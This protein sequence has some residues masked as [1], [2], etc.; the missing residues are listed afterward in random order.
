MVQ[1]GVDMGNTQVFGYDK[2]KAAA[3]SAAVLDIPGCVRGAFTDFQTEAAL[4]DLVATHFPILKVGPALTFAFREASGPWRRSSERLVASDVPMCWPS[5]SA[6]WTTTPSTGAITSPRDEHE[7][8]IKLYGL[9]DRARYYWPD[10]DVEAAVRTL[11]CNIDASPVPPGLTSQFVGDMLLDGQGPLSRRIV[12]SKVGA[13]VARYRRASGAIANGGRCRLVQSVVFRGISDPLSP[14]AGRGDAVRR[15]HRR[16]LRSAWR[17]D[18]RE[19]RRSSILSRWRGRLTMTSGRTQ[20]QRNPA[21]RRLRADPRKPK[22]G[23]FRVPPDQADGSR[24]SKGASATPSP[25]KRWASLGSSATL[26]TSETLTG[27]S[28]PAWTMMS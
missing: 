25:R 7:R 6:P 26:T 12:R 4:S 28:P 13:V 19:P 14:P 2:P 9:S 17:L 10:P 8:L 18:L 21:R 3:L 27:K 15:S 16:M 23:P 22:C 5:W 20:T 24:R 1:P 11:M